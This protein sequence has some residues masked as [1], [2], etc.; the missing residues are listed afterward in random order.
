MTTTSPRMMTLTIQGTVVLTLLFQIKQKNTKTYYY[1]LVWPDALHGYPF[2][3]F[4][5]RVLQAGRWNFERG[6]KRS[7]RTFLG[8]KMIIFGH[9]SR[10]HF[11]ACSTLFIMHKGCVCKD[12]R[13]GREGDKYV[14]PRNRTIVDT[15]D[16]IWARK[17]IHT[18]CNIQM[19][20]V[21]AG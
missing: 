19:Q 13:L 17:M 16:L 3:M 15:L 10:F 8:L 6:Q 18:V 21:N 7:K 12:I 1:E 9:F 14:C 4:I 11:P 5:I 20:Y 2:Y